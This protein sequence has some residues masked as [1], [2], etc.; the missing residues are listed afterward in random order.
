MAPDIDHIWSSTTDIKIA[1]ADERKILIKRALNQKI[2]VP[3]ILSLMPAWPSQVHPDVDEVN[4]E[5]DEWLLTVNIAEKK[6]AKHR[7]RGNYTFLTA[8][9]YPECKKRESMLV[10]SK[11]LYWIFFWDDEIDTGGELTED[12][13]GTRICCEETN[14][15]VDDCLGPNPNYTP[16]PNIRGTIEM[17]YP[18]LR[19]F[20]AGLGPASTERLRL[21]LHDYINGV[22]RQQQVRQGEHLP[23]PWYHFKIRS[24]DVGVIPSITQNE[25]AMEFELPEYVRRHEAME[26]IVQECTKL[27]VLLNDVLSLQKEF[28][29]SQL[30]NI[31]LLFMN[32]YSLSLKGAVDKVLDLIREHYAICVAAER[33]LPWS[34]DDE[35]LNDD[36]REYVRGCQRLATG[37]AFWSYS[38]ERYFKQ[39]QVNDKWEVLLDLSFVN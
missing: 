7:A 10:I 14:K 24:D 27:T 21:E 8:V 28:R 35:K 39:T 4:K 12:K 37:T 11:F 3:S 31:V 20:R 1:P 15:C 16:P 32:K 34:E 30:E 33:R 29:D 23:D 36:I 2:L 9:Y 17:L 38:C 5:I 13:E 18:I 22:G 6:K 26:S 25:Y 19:D